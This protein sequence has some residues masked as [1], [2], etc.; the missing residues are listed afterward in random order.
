M[1]YACDAD[2]ANLNSRKHLHNFWLWNYNLELVTKLTEHLT[3]QTRDDNMATSFSA[4]IPLY[5]S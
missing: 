1:T 4:Y 2:V 5:L 3:F